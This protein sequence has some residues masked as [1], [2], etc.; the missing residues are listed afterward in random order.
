MFDF[1]WSPDGTR[2]AFT[3]EYA[4]SAE[5][6]VVNSDGSDL[7]NLTNTEGFDI[8][9]AWSP[10]GTQLVI[11]SHL[12]LGSGSWST[13]IYRVDTVEEAPERLSTELEE[14]ITA[15]WSPDGSQI[16]MLSSSGGSILDLY[17]SDANGDDVRRLTFEVGV[18]SFAWRPR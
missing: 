7:R 3:S 8:V 4:D 12:A 1:I 15:S 14:I 10:D 2:I 9:R 17:L 18:T 13:L 16:A 6:F 11:N 5:V